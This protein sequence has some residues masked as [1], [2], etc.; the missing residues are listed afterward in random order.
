ML[1]GNFSSNSSG[2]VATQPFRLLGVGEEEL[3]GGKYVVWSDISVPVQ[4]GSQVVM[5]R[6][7]DCLVYLASVGPRA[8]P[9][10]PIFAQ[11]GLLVLPDPGC[12][13]LVEYLCQGGPWDKFDNKCPPPEARI[14]LHMAGNMEPER[15]VNEVEQMQGSALEVSCLENKNL[16]ATEVHQELMT[17]NISDSLLQLQELQQSS[18]LHDPLLGVSSHECAT[19]EG[20]EMKF[21]EGGQNNPPEVCPSVVECSIPQV[22][23]LIGIML[24][25]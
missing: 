8:I 14:S 9:G 4:R 25:G 22:M 6:C 2:K 10:L 17:I 11:S 16:N 12:F 3:E 15:D 13:A 7:A 21:F 20:A 19:C 18:S 24:V 23:G 5:A 1:V